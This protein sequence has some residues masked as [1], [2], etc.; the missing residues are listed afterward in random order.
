[1]KK[2]II[3]LL[4]CLLTSC[5]NKLSCEKGTLEGEKCKIVLS[6]SPIMAC[7]GGY[8]LNKETNK[9]ENKLIIDAQPN[10]IC[11]YTYE[12]GGD[13]CISI[14]AYDKEEKKECVTTKEGAEAI[15]KDDVCYEKTCTTKAEDGTCLEYI[16]TP[17]DYKVTKVC[18]EGTNI[19]FGECHKITVQKTEYE[20][21]LGTYDKENKKCIILDEVDIEPSCKDGYIYYKEENTCEKIIYENA[22]KK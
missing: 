5:G 19:A 13:R 3:L 21:K 18:P 9:C 10:Y 6:E 22:Y 12:N 2:I 8:E 11:P 17:I 4:I 16:E 1:M 20:C 14:V 15:E 7:P